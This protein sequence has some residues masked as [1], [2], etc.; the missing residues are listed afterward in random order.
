MMKC[1]IVDDDII[2]S[3]KLQLKIKTYLD[4]SFNH[5]HIDII[6]SDFHQHTYD[7]YDLLFL[8][9]D[10]KTHNGIKLAKEIQ[11]SKFHTLIIFVSS[12]NECVFDALTT[13]PLFFMRKN[14]LDKDFQTLTNILNEVLK[15]K[16]KHFQIKINGRE[17]FIYNRDIQYISVAGHD[18]TINTGHQFYTLRSSLNEILH[19]ISDIDII[20]VSKT[21]AVNLQNVMSLNHDTILLKNNVKIHIGRAYKENVMKTYQEFLL[22]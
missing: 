6:S 14:Y 20:Q 21:V 1:A 8:D 5:Y 4:Q 12:L 7:S 9:I 17:I 3:K 19:T 11:T 13:H 16:F 15:H 10:L 2:F 22:R 18:I